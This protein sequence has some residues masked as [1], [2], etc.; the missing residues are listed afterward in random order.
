MAE[1][2]EEHDATLLQAKKHRKEMAMTQSDLA[3]V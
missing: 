1:L 2:T 3:E